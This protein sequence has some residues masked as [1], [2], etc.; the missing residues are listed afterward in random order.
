GV[1][2]SAGASG[3]GRVEQLVCGP[4]PAL[5][6]VLA[7]NHPDVVFEEP[8]TDTGR[9]GGSIDPHFEFADLPAGGIEPHPGELLVRAEPRIDAYEEFTRM[10]FDADRKSTRLNSS[11]VSISYAVFCL[12]KKN[13]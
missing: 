8:H 10:R 3:L 12:K 13:R 9:I 7:P 11:H 2:G 6:P 4:G 1:A 5:R